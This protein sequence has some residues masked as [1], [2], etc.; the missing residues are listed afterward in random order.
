MFLSFIILSFNVQK[1][2]LQYQTSIYELIYN[3]NQSMKIRAFLV[4]LCHG[5]KR[6]LYK[7]FSEGMQF[8]VNNKGAY[9]KYLV[10]RLCI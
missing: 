1:S 9:S 7:I 8:W 10:I 3:L 2:N 5:K 4:K 6:K